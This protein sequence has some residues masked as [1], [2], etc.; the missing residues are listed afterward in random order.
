MSSK[1]SWNFKGIYLSLLTI[2]LLY[3]SWGLPPF[4]T[5]WHHLDER[6]FLALNSWIGTSPLAQKF[7][8]IANHRIMDFWHD[9]V[10][11]TF[12]IVY[13]IKAPKS[14]KLHRTGQFLFTIALF[15]A[16]IL[17]INKTLI[18]ENFKILRESPSLAYP[19]CHRLS[20]IIDW[21]YV[22]DYSRCSF[23]SDHGTTA[24]LFTGAIFIL[25]GWRTGM[26]AL[27]YGIFFCLPRMIVGGH[28]LTDVIIGSNTITLIVL[29]LGYFTPLCD[30]CARAF[31]KL[32]QLKGSYEPE[33]L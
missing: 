9:I 17:L 29:S 24:T 26:L 20:Q 28:W 21:I 16:T 6:T 8:A 10:M 23:P 32:F 11:F 15:A 13:I 7:W 19:D 33:N 12:F 3:L 25:M 30:I 31:C 27:C 1:F 22:K 2:I 18:H 14:D 4:N 5:V